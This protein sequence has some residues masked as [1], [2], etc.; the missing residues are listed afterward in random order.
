MEKP[1]AAGFHLGGSGC[2]VSHFNSEGRANARSYVFKRL[3]F[4]TT[5]VRLALPRKQGL[6]VRLLHCLRLTLLTV[7][8]L[9]YPG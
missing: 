9:I 5:S 2:L 3:G 6:F 1:P 8:L 4:V 7:V